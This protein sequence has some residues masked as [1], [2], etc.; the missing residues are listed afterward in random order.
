[1]LTILWV[2]PRHRRLFVFLLSAG[3]LSHTC[4]TLISADAAPHAG[5]ARPSKWWKLSG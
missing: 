1:M 2:A 4:T 3:W 5:S